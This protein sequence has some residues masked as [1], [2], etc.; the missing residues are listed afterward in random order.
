VK[1]QKLNQRRKIM[2]KRKNSSKR[3]A[4]TILVIAMLISSLF[5]TMAGAADTITL[6]GET[7]TVTF[8]SS[9]TP[10]IRVERRATELT[11]EELT[12]FNEAMA[13]IDYDNY[14][15]ITTEYFKIRRIHLMH[16]YSIDF[17]SLIDNEADLARMRS[18]GISHDTSRIS[19]RDT[20]GAE[21]TWAQ[22][23]VM[24]HWTGSEV[25]ILSSHMIADQNP[26]GGA[27][28]T[29]LE[30]RHGGNSDVRIVQGSA[31]FNAPGIP[32]TRYTLWLSGDKH[33]NTW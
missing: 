27:V 31:T 6:N 15:I 14:E 9:S 3:L 16:G 7:L 20:N 12:E 5:T 18:G 26:P 2:F 23:S 19:I 24:F 13:N 29:G 11:A 4:S 22:M 21:V 33:G 10:T 30:T 17:I 8:Y 25:S 32:S 28:W 1:N